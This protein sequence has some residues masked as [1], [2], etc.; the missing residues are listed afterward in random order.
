MP[1]PA[2]ATATMPQRGL[3]RRCATTGTGFAHPNT[4]A[5]AMAR[6]SG[7]ISVPSGSTWRSGLKLSR[8]RSAAVGSPSHFAIQP[9]AT[10]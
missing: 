5:P 3:R 9:C 4:G 2:S 7:R 8:F 1:G 10:S 6:P